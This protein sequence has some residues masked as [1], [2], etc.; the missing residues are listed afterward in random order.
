[1]KKHLVFWVE[2][3]F[4]NPTSF[5]KILSFL[6]LPLSWLY[7]F[8]MYLRYKN[9][10][11]EDFSLKIVS[12]GNLSVGGSGKTPLVSALALRYENVA[13]VL[14]GY[15]RES[16]G[17]VVVKESQ[18]ILCDVRMSGDEA[19]IYAHKI[20]H[21]I[22]IVSEDRKEGI[23]KAKELGAKL[24]FL[25]DAY[26]KHDIKKLDILIEVESSNKSCL[27]SGPFRE[28]L[29]DSKDV[30]LLKEERDFKRVVE[31][32]NQKP[33]MSLVTAIA[34]P[35]RLDRFLPEVISKNYFEDHHA[36]SENELLEVLRKDK[37]DSLLVTY[38]DFVKI[39]NYN[40]PLSLLDLSM[41]VD[42]RVF[43]AIGNYIA[44]EN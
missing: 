8:G 23:L 5:Q 33:K 14:R 6:L 17:L 43:E 12:V 30:L 28:R 32:K 21:A 13:I 2:E 15:G 9:K 42:E 11:L 36:F 22:I 38:K 16:K 44:K 10:T 37:S 24:L 20:P 29:W 4:Y 34:R 3:Y 39:E 1:M 31:L 27:P 26:S 40:L 25:D 18:K 35:S 41:E 19:M 7:C